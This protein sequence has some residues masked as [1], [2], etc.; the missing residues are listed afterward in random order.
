ML[1][2]GADFTVKNSEDMLAIDL[3]PDK[4]VRSASSLDEPH[5]HQYRETLSD[6]YQVR[7]FVLQGAE[8]EGIEIPE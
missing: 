4:E 2:E 3:A 1:K 7:K 6:I 5:G 8:R